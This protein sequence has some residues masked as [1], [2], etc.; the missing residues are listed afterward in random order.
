MLCLFL[1]AMSWEHSLATLQ[2]T[3]FAGH[4][5]CVALYVV[6]TLVPMPKSAKKKTA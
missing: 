5:I 4:I 1:Q 6:F 2:N 3:Y